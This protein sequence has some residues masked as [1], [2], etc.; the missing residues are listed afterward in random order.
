[1]ISVAVLSNLKS[2]VLVLY[3]LYGTDKVI[4][5]SNWFMC[6]NTFKN[7]SSLGFLGLS[8]FLSPLYL[9]IDFHSDKPITDKSLIYIV[10]DITFCKDRNSFLACFCWHIMLNINPIFHNMSLYGC[11]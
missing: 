9:H 10:V 7:L 4:S 1:M 11:I 6:N 8:S 3:I 5:D 2:E